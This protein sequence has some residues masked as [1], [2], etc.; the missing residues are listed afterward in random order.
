MDETLALNFSESLAWRNRVGGPTIRQHFSRV[1][2]DLRLFPGTPRHA[3]PL[4]VGWRGQTASQTPLLALLS[5]L[6]ETILTCL[7]IYTKIFPGF[8]ELLQTTPI[9]LMFSYIIEL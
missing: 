5:N 3:G 2:H 8:L 6:G 7:K 1:R 4:V 9:P